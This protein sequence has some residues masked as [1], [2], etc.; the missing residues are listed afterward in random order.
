[1]LW[2]QHYHL[3]VWALRSRTSL[4]WVLLCA[5]T[6]VARFILRKVW[7]P[8]S[9]DCFEGWLGRLW[10]TCFHLRIFSG[11][12]SFSPPLRPPYYSLRNCQCM[13]IAQM[14]S[15][16]QPP[17]TQLPLSTRVH[18]GRD[19]EVASTQTTHCA[20]QKSVSTF[21][22]FY[23]VLRRQPKRSCFAQC[24][25][26][27]SPYNRVLPTTWTIVD[28][29]STQLVGRALSQSRQCSAHSLHLEAWS[30]PWQYCDNFDGSNRSQQFL[31]VFNFE[32]S[33]HWRHKSVTL[34]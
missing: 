20:D 7:L 15:F 28:N 19:F 25:T 29:S 2:Q 17:R 24:A 32:G 4:S 9:W 14:Q 26:S 31:L 3:L 21:A 13:R 8:F 30:P 12:N 22:C 33:T 6:D 11:T 27:A 18:R 34:E 5:N 10:L 1:M 23:N 16:L